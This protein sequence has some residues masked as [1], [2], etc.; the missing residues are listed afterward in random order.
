MREG[1]E[2]TGFTPDMLEMKKIGFSNLHGDSKAWKNIWD[3]GH[4]VDRTRAVQSVAELVD[5]LVEEYRLTS[6]EL[7]RIAD[8]PCDIKAARADL[9]TG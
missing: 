8:W 1:L 4:S 2:A 3:A 7:A 5:E 9:V 6:S